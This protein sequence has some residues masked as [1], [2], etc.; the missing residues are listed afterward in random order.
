VSDV[1]LRQD[2]RSKENTQGKNRTA[3]KVKQR[4]LHGKTLPE[5]IKEKEQPRLPTGSR[6]VFVFCKTPC[7]IDRS[8]SRTV[9]SGAEW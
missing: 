5:K 6:A 2:R 4:P 1:C 8:N 9:F 3:E 7:V